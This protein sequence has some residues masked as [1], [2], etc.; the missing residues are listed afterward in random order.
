MKS[1]FAK[2]IKRNDYIVCNT[3]IIDRREM[4]G[5]WNV[6]QRCWQTEPSLDKKAARKIQSRNNRRYYNNYGNIHRPFL[7]SVKPAAENEVSAVVI[8]RGIVSDLEE[9]E[10]GDQSILNVRGSFLDANDNKCNAIQ[11]D[12]NQKVVIV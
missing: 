3:G 2:D 5:L 8:I 7:L 12:P 11:L 6:S 4:Y 1:I 9:G 10:A